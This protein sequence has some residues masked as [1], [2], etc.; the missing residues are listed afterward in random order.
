[1]VILHAIQATLHYGDY[2]HFSN[3]LKILYK[4]VSSDKMTVEITDCEKVYFTLTYGILTMKSV[5]C[6]GAFKLELLEHNRVYLYPLTTVI[7][8]S[9]NVKN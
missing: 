1:M 3:L 2:T 8:P 7:V 5:A 6:I 4:H 9:L